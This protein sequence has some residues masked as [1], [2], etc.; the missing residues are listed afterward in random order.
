MP[1]N[2][3]TQTF[4]PKKSLAKKKTPRGGRGIFFSISLIIFL[5]TAVSSGAVYAY[6]AYLEKRVESLSLSLERAKAAFEPSVIVEFKKLNKRMSAAE[7]ILSNHVALTS[8]FAALEDITLK[9]VRFTRFSYASGDG[10]ATLELSGVAQSYASIALQS[11]A[12]GESPY[13]KNPIFSNLG[14][15]KEGNITFDLITGV[16]SSLI[17]YSQNTAQR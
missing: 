13:F 3:P 6:G 12:F 16:D 5:L 15:D 2:E 17:L 9:S 4:I 14:L 7:E 11:D 10:G 1:I 8:L